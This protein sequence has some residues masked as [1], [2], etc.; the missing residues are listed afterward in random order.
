MI[1]ELVRKVIAVVTASSNLPTDWA[2]EEQVKAYLVGL[3]GPLAALIAWLIRQK[4]PAPPIVGSELVNL[5][6]RE[7]EW[8]SATLSPE[9]V[10]LVVKI[11]LYI[12]A[13]LGK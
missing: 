1:L 8:G 10:E 12:L 9:L 11:I 2:D 4:G 5:V 13:R 3:A 6:K 7:C